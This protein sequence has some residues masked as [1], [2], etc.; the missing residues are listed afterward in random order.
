MMKRQWPR[1][2][3]LL[4]ILPLLLTAC[5]APA[6]TASSNPASSKVAASS[7]AISS[8]ASAPSSVEESSQPVSSAA[9][10]S[11]PAPAK[12][13]TISSDL[14]FSK[15][16]NIS[17]LESVAYSASDTA[18]AA[19]YLSKTSTFSDIKGK[20]FDFVRLPVD[21]RKYYDSSSGALLTSGE[22]NIANVDGVIKRATDAGLHIILVLY[23]WSNINPSD[24]A[25]VTLFQGLWKAV[26]EHYKSYSDKLSFELLNKPAFKGDQVKALNTVQNN[27]IA[28][29]RK[30]NPDRLIFYAVGDSSAAWYLSGM[31]GTVAPNPPKNDKHIAVSVQTYAPDKF[32]RQKEG[33]NVRLYNTSVGDYTWMISKVGTYALEKNIPGII[34]EFALPRWAVQADIREYL[35]LTMEKCVEYGV[36]LCYW[37]YC[38]DSTDF[39][40]ARAGWNGAWNDDILTGLGLK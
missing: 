17:G 6:D 29:I 23:N 1:V 11:K 13:T 15:G 27:A 2:L 28:E 35:D 34:S 16:L 9:A 18:N 31:S 32:V 3:C 30:T 25:Q 38:D 8:E 24:N 40:P 39:L 5:A 21:L 36:P 33:E 10:S 20:G 26:A 4:L 22:Y 7:K 12:A 37:S 19:Y 14:P